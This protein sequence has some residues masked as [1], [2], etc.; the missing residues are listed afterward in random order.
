MAYSDYIDRSKTGNLVPVEYFEE[1]IKSAT[2]AS[3]V[4]GHAR[5]LRD[6]T[7]GEM[8]LTVTDVLPT[9]YF[10]NGDT[11]ARGVTKA[12]W[13][14]VKLV[15]EEVAA[16]IPV[17]TNLIDDANVPIWNEVMPLL[18]EAIAAKIDAAIIN[19]TD[20]PTSWGT[21]IVAEAETRGHV[22][23]V[24][25][26]GA[27]Y[28]NLIMGDDGLLSKVENNG[29]FVNGHIANIAM[30]AKLRGIRDNNGAPI[31][32]AS[33]QNANQ[34]QLDGAP[35]T[36]P[37]NGCFNDSKVLDVAGDWSQLV[38]SIRKDATFDVFDQG[39]ITDPSNENKV[40]TNLMQQHMVA[41]MVTMRIGF[42]LP[43]PVNLTNKDKTKRYPFAVLKAAS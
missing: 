15:A 3:A 35:M 36:F 34:Y 42:A 13:A 30:R 8:A 27:D 28:Y 12:E 37:R 2:E 6:M 11:G 24:P 41:L 4:M 9:A 25:A 5:R 7:R 33:M 17:S 1:V 31:F 18:T 32:T 21:S 29:Y 23:T 43:N 20:L 40:V 19:G 14:G 22:V 26:S 38:Y 39:V 16:L 10:T